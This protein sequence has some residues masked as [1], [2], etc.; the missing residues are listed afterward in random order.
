MH[1]STDRT[2]IAVLD[3]DASV[4]KAMTRLFETTTYRANTYASPEEFLA[5]L[6]A[7]APVCLVVDFHMPR[8]N[9]L[10]FLDHMG[11]QG[12]RIPTI[13]ITAFDE[14]DTRRRCMDAGA[15][16]YFTK[17]VRRAELLETIGRLVG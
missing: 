8:M 13:V 5:T 7:G 16:A 15:S 17:P 3:D 9:A 14:P 1:M 4:R 2:H 11:R 12:I 6:G 10:E